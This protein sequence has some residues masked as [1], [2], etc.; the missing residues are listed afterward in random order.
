MA[1]QIEKMW[2]GLEKKQD[3]NPIKNNKPEIM[4][5]TEQMVSIICNQRAYDVP[6]DVAEEIKSLQQQRATLLITVSGALDI[7]EDLSKTRDRFLAPG[8]FDDLTAKIT[9]R[10][11]N[12]RKIIAS[13]PG[14]GL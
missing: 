1:N 13:P 14:P 8:T 3:S 2:E 4:D 9:A 11:E 10:I 5:E 6:K 12:I 7:I